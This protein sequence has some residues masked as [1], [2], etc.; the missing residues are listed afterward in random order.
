MQLQI[1]IAIA[2]LKRRQTNHKHYECDISFVWRSSERF[3]INRWELLLTGSMLIY[4]G[5]VDLETLTGP[6]ALEKAVY[7][8]EAQK[9]SPVTTTIV[10]FV[11]S[12]Q[13][14]VVTDTKRK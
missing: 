12:S 13:G 3:C 6:E 14:I 7:Q 5:A 8:I 2:S 11:L 10:N 4:I 1:H 9:T